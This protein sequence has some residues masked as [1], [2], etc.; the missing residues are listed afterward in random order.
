[1]AV[2]T[3]VPRA[4]SRRP[5]ECPDSVTANSSLILNIVPFNSVI[6]ASFINKTSCILNSVTSVLVVSLWISFYFLSFLVNITSLN[7]SHI[8]YCFRRINES[9]SHIYNLKLFNGEDLN[10]EIYLRIEAVWLNVETLCSKY[11]KILHH[12]YKYYYFFI[13]IKNCARFQ[14]L[15]LI[16]LLNYNYHFN[17]CMDHCRKLNFFVLIFF[18]SY[19]R[20]MK[21]NRK[22]IMKQE[23]LRINNILVSNLKTYQIILF[24]FNERKIFLVINS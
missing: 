5:S 6:R 18:L 2:S 20:T 13:Q 22:S 16:K 24:I 17:I 1:M 7:W 8:G 15:F 12:F 23:N 19:M 4:T 3:A 11:L 14:D 10:D 21:K 9:A